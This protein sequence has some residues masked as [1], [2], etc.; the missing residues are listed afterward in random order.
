M[1]IENIQETNET[2]QVLPKRE[3]VKVDNSAYNDRYK[4]ILYANDNIVCERYFKINYF[5][6]ES[7]NSEELLYCMYSIQELIQNDLASK[8]RIYTWYNTP[9]P[10]KMNGFKPEGQGFGKV[11]WIG[12]N[13]EG[14]PLF[15]LAKNRNAEYLEYPEGSIPEFS[16]TIGE[17]YDVYFKFSFQ[18]AQKSKPGLNPGDKPIYSDYK[19]VY[20]MMWDA[21]YYPKDVRNSVDITNNDYRYKNRDI[22]SMNFTQTLNYRM[23][24]GKSDLCYEIIKRICAVTS[25]PN[26]EEREM[27]YTKSTW[28]GDQKYQYTAYNRAYVE[29]WRK[30]TDKKTRKY[31]HSIGIEY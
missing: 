7:L 31:F 25:N 9:G 18:I 5:I 6:S 24:I 8:S 27:E 26:P 2:Q 22:N 23:V 11:E 4:F 15:Y 17:P 29:G 16:P 21:T 14:K 19:P 12:P 20:E 10:V 1:D 3:P 13:D 28:Y 30:A